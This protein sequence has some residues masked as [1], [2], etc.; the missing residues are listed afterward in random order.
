VHIGLIEAPSAA[1][2]AL[3]DPFGDAAVEDRARSYL[4]SNCS[5]CHRK[6]GGGR[7]DFSF[8][9]ETPES[10]IGCDVKP[11]AGDVGIGVNARVIAPGKPD[12]SVVVKRMTDRSAYGMPPL[13]ASLVHDDAVALMKT[14]ISG[15]TACKP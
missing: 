10:G 12:D 15:K 3:P 11:V 2:K 4:H 6:D 13:A 14:W 5:H 8:F 1:P 7:G 9:R